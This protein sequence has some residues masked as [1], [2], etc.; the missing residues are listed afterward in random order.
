M[1]PPSGRPFPGTTVLGRFM[2]PAK[3]KTDTHVEN[4]GNVA[5]LQVQLAALNAAAN[6]IVIT[7]REGAIQWVNA[8]FTKLTG[9]AVS[10]AIG[11][12]PRLL[13]SGK[14]EERLYCG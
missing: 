8:A 14:H 9:Y 1:E 3:L 7:D 4:G 11:Q 10:E 13:K 5:M 12:N 2:D 6:S